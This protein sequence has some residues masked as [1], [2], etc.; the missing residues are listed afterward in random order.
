MHQSSGTIP[1]GYYSPN[2]KTIINDIKKILLNSGKTINQVIKDT[3][4]M[5]WFMANYKFPEL[6]Y[7]E[8]CCKIDEY[9]FGKFGSRLRHLH[10]YANSYS[11][12]SRYL[13]KIGAPRSRNEL[14]IVNVHEFYF[15]TF[16][17]KYYEGSLF[18]DEIFSPSYPQKHIKAL[19][20]E[21]KTCDECIK[22]KKAFDISCIKNELDL[23]LSNR[24]KKLELELELK[25]GKNELDLELSN[26]V[27][28]LE[29][30]LEHK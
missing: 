18:L 26:R 19:E 9:F 11:I 4:F 14:A 17:S 20:C 23:E 6:F 24:V 21:C 8:D 10:N 25:H 29:L 15:F 16:T 7:Y 1:V 2:I 12:S 27:K 5:K 3:H 30:E 28:K 22:R 13:D